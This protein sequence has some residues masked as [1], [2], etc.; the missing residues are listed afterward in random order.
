M[1]TWGLRVKV[2]SL[3][4]KTCTRRIFRRMGAKQWDT[5]SVEAF[6]EAKARDLKR[7]FP[8]HDYERIRVGPLAFNFI[9]VGPRK[10]PTER[11][12]S[13]GAPKVGIPHRKQSET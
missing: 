4:N 2:F 7:K 1:T 6:L 12:E 9:S 8:T 3:D 11:T 13:H 10:V 5:E